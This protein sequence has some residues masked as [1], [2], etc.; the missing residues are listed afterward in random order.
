MISVSVFSPSEI[1]TSSYTKEQLPKW[2]INVVDYRKFGD[3]GKTGVDIFDLGHYLIGPTFLIAKI[4]REGTK[5]T[6]R[7]RTR[8]S[9]GDYIEFERSEIVSNLEYDSL[10]GIIPQTMIMINGEL[11]T[12]EKFKE[13]QKVHDF[14]SL[15]DF[16]ANDW[17]YTKNTETFSQ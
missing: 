9:N 6:S 12:S 10:Q 1:A 2:E 13:S 4:Y 14:D 8:M 5:T 16:Y 3:I 11:I 15:R 17:L 7:L